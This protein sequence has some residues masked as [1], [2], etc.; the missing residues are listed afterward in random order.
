[1]LRSL[2]QRRIDDEKKARI[3]E[4]YPGITNELS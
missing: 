2:E 3:E 4:R 1:M